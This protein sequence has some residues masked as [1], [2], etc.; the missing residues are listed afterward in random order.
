MPILFYDGRCSLCAREMK[1]L[2]PRLAGK[3]FLKNLHDVDFKEFAGVG[4]T[5]MM[6]QLHLW[7]GQQFITGFD[8]SLYYWQ[9]A[10]FHRT[11]RLLRLPVIYATSNGCYRWWARWREKSGKCRIDP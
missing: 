11:T 7:D 2:A 4:K 9:L 6:Q 1:L 8:A 3:I 5:S 10:G